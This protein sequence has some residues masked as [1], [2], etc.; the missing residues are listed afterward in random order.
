MGRPDNITPSKKNPGGT[1]A[2][3][4]ASLDSALAEEYL[5]LRRK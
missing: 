5:T 4:D 3:E 2:A 1:P